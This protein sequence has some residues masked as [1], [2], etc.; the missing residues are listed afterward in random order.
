MTL[1]Y[2]RKF[3]I[4]RQS[5][6]FLNDEQHIIF[7]ALKNINYRKNEHK[8]AEPDN[9]VLDG[10]LWFDKVDELLKY[11]DMRSLSWK[12][13]FSKKF[14]ITDQ[15]LNLVMPSSPV[16]GQLWLYNGVLMY[17]DGSQWNPVKAMIQDETQWS[18][19]AF[20]DFM[21][22][23]PLNPAP[24]LIVD[25]NDTNVDISKFT[26]KLDDTH[27]NTNVIEPKTTKWGTDGWDNAD[28]EE[29]TVNEIPDEKYKSQFI[30]PNLNTDRIFIDSKLDKTYEEIT[31]VCLNY[32]TKDVYD[33][34]VSCVH[35]NPGKLTK[36]TKRLIK[37]DKLNSTINVPA[38]NTEFYGFKN[39]KVGGDFL[40][41]STNQDE[42]DYIPTG[43]YIVLNYK[44]NQNYDYI[45]AISYEFTWIKAAGSFDYWNSDHP[46]TSFYLANL[47]EPINVHAN[48]MKLEEAIYDVNYQDKTVTINDKDA[49]NVD[50][51]MWSPYK[52]QFGYIR[53]TDLEGNGIIRLHRKVSIPLVFVGGMLIHPLYGGLKFKDDKIIIPN[54]SG[55]DSMKNQAWCVV[56][57]LS[58]DNELMY[59]ERGK[60]EK[61][62][63][64]F[65]LSQDDYLEGDSFY[66]HGKLSETAD[67]EGFKDYI[68]ASGTIRGIND[69]II[70]YNNQKITKDDGIILFINGFMIR[71]Q[72][73][74]RDHAEGCITV[75]PELTIGQE[76]V[77]LRDHDKRLYADTT[78]QAAYATGYL[79]ESLV[80][81]NGQVLVDSTC[82]STI[83]NENEE[84]LFAIDNEIKCFIDCDNPD[85]IHWKIY[86][87]WTYEWEDLEER[88]QS[89]VE[90]IG[91][92]YSKQLTSIKINLKIKSTD[93]VDVY[94]F[95]YSNST[96]GLYKVG[97]ATFLETDE[98]DGMQVYVMGTNPFA[99]GQGNLNIYRNG[100]KLIAG[101][102]YKELSEHNYIKMINPV[103]TENDKISYIIEPIEAG[104]EYGHESILL[105]NT[106]SIQ[107]NIYKIDEGDS[108]P[109]LY[110]GRL[111]V[112]VNGLRLSKKDW[113]L[114]DNKRIML[115]LTDYKAIGSAENYPTETKL[116]GESLIEINHKYPDNI[117]VEIRKDYDRNEITIELKD[118]DAVEIYTEDYGIDNS[119][120]ECKDEVLFYL[121]GQYLG[122]SRNNENDYKLDIYK[123]CIAILNSS[124][125]EKLQSDPLKRVLDRNSLA[126]VSWKTRNNKEKYVSNKK[127]NLT[128]VWR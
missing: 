6:Q 63:A 87:Q 42:G 4:G 53:E 77:L 51:Q 29:P 84:S 64:S 71:N 120:V 48:G 70:R 67:A 104:E 103:D 1:P 8:G 35:I 43:D 109:D 69:N 62:E 113:V 46:K 119:I 14:Q 57:M 23:S 11:Y 81:L 10:A 32:P 52:K 18:N 107:P 75:L 45:L 26:H 55:I 83:N 115:N 121:N 20:E 2:K 106:N 124:I 50:I 79:D 114:L 86:N 116:V 92:S 7:E 5:E 15:M 9:A 105:T 98:D 28:I 123:G 80:Y 82:L 68:L 100:I 27:K 73:I 111:T 122:M 99:F 127:N 25:G 97:D 58:N 93:R 91:S 85:N 49:E 44:A 112:Y 3:G 56:D 78:L 21:I 22:V 108:V 90:L 19:A 117:L 72:D 12:T 126:Y 37:V 16:L 125:V 128:L 38:Y 110:P 65:V 59:S 13:M 101:L 36:I 33:K 94:S 39:G 54:H 17:F 30:V 88:D 89:S 95:K 24:S 47:K 31:K 96:S 40:I 66:I 41:K 61:G 74:I 60:V 34:T 76:Y 118:K 102:D